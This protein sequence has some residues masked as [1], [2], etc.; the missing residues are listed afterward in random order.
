MPSVPCDAQIH[1]CHD[2]RERA[3]PGATVVLVERPQ[4]AHERRVE[5]VHV[6]AGIERPPAV[7]EEL[8][9]EQNAFGRDRTLESPTRSASARIRSASGRAAVRFSGDAPGSRRA[10]SSETT[11]AQR[12]A[13]ASRRLRSEVSSRARQATSVGRPR[14]GGAEKLPVRQSA[15]AREASALDRRRAAHRRRRTSAPSD[16][17]VALGNEARNSRDERDQAQDEEEASRL[18]G[19]GTRHSSGSDRQPHG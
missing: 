8:L 19:R 12:P 9:D 2:R 13:R 10:S 14:H 5:L 7:G 4:A 17:S 3:I 18:S 15:E 1:V 6:V 11:L 16:E